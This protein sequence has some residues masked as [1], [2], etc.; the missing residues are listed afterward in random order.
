MALQDEVQSSV[1]IEEYER[2]KETLGHM[3]S[4]V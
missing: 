4:Q 1:P 3:D 2:L